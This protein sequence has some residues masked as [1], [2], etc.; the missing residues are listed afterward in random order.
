[1]NQGSVQTF[2]RSNAAVAGLVLL[3]GTCSADIRVPA[4][5]PTVQAA[6]DAA[7]LTGGDTIVLAPGVYRESLVIPAGGLAIE[8]RSESPGDDATVEQTVLSGDLDADGLGDGRILRVAGSDESATLTIRGLTFANGV[9]VNDEIGDDPDTQPIGGAVRMDAGSLAIESCVFL[10]NRV[11]GAEESRGGAVAFANGTLTIDGSRFEGNERNADDTGFEGY[12]AFGGGGVFAE[13]AAIDITASIFETNRANHGAAVHAGAG[14]MFVM[15]ACDIVGNEIYSDG[16]VLAFASD[17]TVTDSTF[18]ANTADQLCVGLKGRD[19]SSFLVRGS[20]FTQNLNRVGFQGV[21]ATADTTGLNSELVEGCDF[22]G[23]TTNAGPDSASVI[24]LRGTLTR[25]DECYFAANRGYAWVTCNS[26]SSEGSISNS[27]FIGIITQ[28]GTSDPD[29]DD[30]LLPVIN[31]TFIDPMQGVIDNPGRSRFVSCVSTA[32]LVIPVSRAGLFVSRSS[33]SLYPNDQIDD[34]PGS[35]GETNVI[36]T[37][38]Q[39]LRTPDHGGDGWGDDPTT[40]DLDESANDDYGDLR[41]VPGS[42]AIDAGDSTAI[43]ADIFDLDSDGDTSEPLPF[44]IAGN[45][46]RLD[47]ANTPDTGVGPAPVVD[48]G[49]YEFNG[50]CSIADLA[51][52]FGLYGLNDI[53][54]FMSLFQ[55]SDSAVDFAPPMGVLDLADIVAFVK[56]YTEGC[57]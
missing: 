30:N 37:A 48:M 12:P 22:I 1:M 11:D 46:R 19:C 2:S 6:I 4:D 24:D 38:P 29:A 39:F 50:V 45:P 44:D 43:P 21:V 5:H 23:N 53:G 31:C 32:D 27:V 20:R 41:L 16:T 49:A 36:D 15:D 56:A 13:S 25:L 9:V 34:F 33:N 18:D 10:R 51:E 35:D 47:D 42:P 28:A 54:L 55:A 52:P 57:P 14:S 8:L 3:A 7:S 26:A 17:C 40:P